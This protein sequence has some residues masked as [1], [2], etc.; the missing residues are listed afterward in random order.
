VTFDKAMSRMERAALEVQISEFGQIP[1]QLFEEKHPAKK[2][3]ILCLDIG[4]NTEDK[5]VLG[6]KIV[7]LTD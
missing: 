1:I 4:Q 5:R 3:R 2:A 7:A 6:A